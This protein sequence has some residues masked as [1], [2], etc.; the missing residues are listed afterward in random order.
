MEAT[1]PD[2]TKLVTVH[3][4]TMIP[5]EIFYGSEVISRDERRGTPAAD[6]DH[7][8]RRSSVQVGSHVH[9]R[10]PIGLSFD[11]A[12]AHGYRLD[13]PAVTAGA[14]QAGAIPKPRRGWVSVGRTAQ[15][16]SL[17]LN[18]PGPDR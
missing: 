3:Q 10:R 6:A 15:V 7:Q 13:I 14:L 5:G 17:T 4:P 12:T 18:P 11:R 8:R 16:P 1:F 2:G 9:L